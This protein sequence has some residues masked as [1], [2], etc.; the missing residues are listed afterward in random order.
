MG[1]WGVRVIGF[2]SWAMGV[3]PGPRPMKPAI[4]TPYHPI[5]LTPHH[6]PKETA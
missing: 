5:T 4:Q 1:G 2:G 3:G 6:P